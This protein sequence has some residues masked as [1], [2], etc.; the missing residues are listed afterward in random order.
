MDFVLKTNAIFTSYQSFEWCKTI[1]A[2]AQMQGLSSLFST[3]KSTLPTDLCARYLLF[4]HNYLVPLTLCIYFA[5]VSYFVFP[6]NTFPFPG[7]KADDGLQ[8]QLKRNWLR[9]RWKEWCVLVDFSFVLSI[10][11]AFA[12]TIA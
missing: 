7:D 1:T 5:D 11:L 8:K 9:D 10:S 4:T 2:Q 3:S 6:G 12:F